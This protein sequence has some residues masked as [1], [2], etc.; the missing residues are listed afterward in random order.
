MSAPL[1]NKRNLE[2]YIGQRIRLFGKYSASLNAANDGFITVMSTDGVEIK[3]RLSPGIMKPMDLGNNVP[4]VVVVSGRVEADSSVTIE[5]PIADLGTDMDM[6][7]MDEAINLQFRKE[8]AHLFYASAAH[9]S[10][11]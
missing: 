2:R 4:R 8:F 5:S 1:V 10:Y 6:N 3:C 11:A 9:S 7:L